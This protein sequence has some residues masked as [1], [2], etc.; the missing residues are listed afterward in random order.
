MQPSSPRKSRKILSILAG[1]GLGCL[2]LSLF[3]TGYIDLHSMLIQARTR[4]VLAGLACTKSEPL[5]IR[6]GAKGCFYVSDKRALAAVSSFWERFF[7]GHDGLFS[8]YVHALPGYVP[9]FGRKSVFYQR[10]IPSQ[11]AQWGEMNMCEAEQR[12]LANALLDWSNERFVLLSE[13]CIPL[14]PFPVIY[15][16]LIESKES[17]VGSFDDPGPYGRGRYNPKMVPEV[18]ISQWRKGSQWFEVQRALAIDI[19]S[20]TKYYPKFKEFCRPPCYVDEHYFPT[21]L[22]IKSPSLIA[23]RSVTWVDWSRGGSHP[24]TFGKGDITEAFLKRVKEDQKCQYNGQESSVCLL[25]AR[26]F[27]PNALKPL[28]EFS[29]SVLGFNSS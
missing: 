26:K 11:P 8:I 24:A 2:I 7:Q 15:K 29:S 16:Y 6:K 10:Q 22:T 9:E 20:D 1:L 28:L 27:A 12:L 4:V 13:S 17:F 3:T 14:F 23:G 18:D 5:S 21:M 19:I 25:F